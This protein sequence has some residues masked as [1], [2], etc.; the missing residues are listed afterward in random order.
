MRQKR[1]RHT[2]EFKKEA[3]RLMI[4]EGLGAPE[5]S[6]KLGVSIGML[7]KWK[8]HFLGELGLASKSDSEL[9]PVQMAEE[10]SR[11]R[12]ELAREKRINEILKKTVSFFAKE[13]S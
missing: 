10:L 4:M 6:K 11:V 9:S 12:K 2:E 7:Y 1:Q 5:V 3:A 13:E 8:H